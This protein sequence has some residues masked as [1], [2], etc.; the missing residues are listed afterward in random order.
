MEKGSIL[1]HCRAP[2]DRQR[3]FVVKFAPLSRAVNSAVECHLHTVE[4]TGSIPV[5]PTKRP[6]QHKDF[7]PAKTADRRFFLRQSPP[8][9]DV[10]YTDSRPLHYLFFGNRQEWILQEVHRPSKC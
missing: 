6:L 1:F 10:F 2:I 9:V 4:A 7:E 3:A 5:P 8:Y